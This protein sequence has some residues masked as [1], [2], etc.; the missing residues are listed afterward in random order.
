MKSY[1]QS[2]AS[3]KTLANDSAFQAYSKELMIKSNFLLY[4]KVPKVFRLKDV[5]FKSDFS[6]SLSEN[7]EIIKKYS[8]FSWQFSLSD[9][10]IENRVKLNFDPNAK[11]EPQAVWQIKLD[12]QLAQKPRFVINH[13]D[14]ANREIII[15]DKENNVSLINK[16][17]LVLWTIN[18]PDEIISEIQQIDIYQTKRFQYIFNTKTQLYVIDRN[19]NNVGKFPVTLKSIASNGITVVE[20]GN[21]KEL[22]YFVAGEDK[23][24]YAFDRDGRQIPKWNP[25]PT[26]GLVTKPLNHY[27]IGDKD[28][29]V[30]SD[31]MNTYFL[32]R[33]GKKRAGQPAPYNHSAN[34]MYF[35][36]GENP[37]LIGTDLS[38][39]IHLIDF[40]GEAEIK[41]TGK[42]GAGHRFIAEDL[43]GKGTLNYI[44]AD[45]KKLSV[46]GT[47]AKKIFE[48]SFPD[49][50]SEM[51]VIYTPAQGKKLIGVTIGNENKTYLLDNKGAVVRG[52]PLEGNTDLLL[53]KFNEANS[54]INLLIG[55]EGN[56]L[57][58]YRIE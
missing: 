8:T 26:A 23:M 41:E 16:E 53:G 5:L 25:E 45:E 9:K 24:L 48:H 1:I 21:N 31:N 18:V 7:E 15:C 43:E 20:Y 2:L 27:V 4:A 32:D 35:T 42:F 22:R 17:G 50:I 3:E 54:W 46:F 29:L 34:P 19:G 28:F 12:G 47:D 13:K 36:G 30:C 39:K 11:E 58:N 33:Q 56:S 51:P 57:I 38:G 37:R 55:A 49:F 40:T 6:T 10:M 52:F 44:Y 14:L